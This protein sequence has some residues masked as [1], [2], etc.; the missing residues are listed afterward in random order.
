MAK[1]RSDTD[2]NTVSIKAIYNHNT[3]NENLVKND[4]QELE[5]LAHTPYAQYIP[6][7]Y[8]GYTDNSVSNN[9]MITTGLGPCIGL[10]VLNTT[11]KLAALAHI[12]DVT[13]APSV[14][15]IMNNIRS[16]DAQ[17]L[18]IYIAGGNKISYQF[19][20]P[21]VK[22]L[23]NTKNAEIIFNKTF[24]A[25]KGDMEVQ[26]LGIDVNGKF[27][28]DM[29]DVFCKPIHPFKSPEVVNIIK[30]TKG[31]CEY[32]LAEVNFIGDNYI[33]ILELDDFVSM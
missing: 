26:T 9:T 3:D 24:L 29:Q 32:P 1:N 7:H 2:L 31:N 33:P 11:T 10:G 5:K 15:K 16:D 21:I 14:M 6:Q 18:N 19:L 17:K 8:V 13:D 25:N 22:W 12:D 20:S 4:I 27:Y 28:T 23:E 30:A